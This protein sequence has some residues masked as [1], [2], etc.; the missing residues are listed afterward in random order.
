MRRAFTLIEILFVV[1][2]IAIL[3]GF[4][5]PGLKNTFDGIQLNTV[6]SQLQSYMNYLCEHSVVVGKTIYLH[7]DNDGKKY[8]AVTDDESV[9]RTEAIPQGINIEAKEQVITFYPDGSIDKVSIKLSNN[10]NQHVDLT[11]KGV[12]GGVKVQSQ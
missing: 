8:W 6:S 10:N 4:S 5:A 12:F 3:I 11:T 7:I 2:I 1:I 9:L